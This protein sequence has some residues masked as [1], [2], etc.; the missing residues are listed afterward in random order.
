MPSEA[1]NDLL[2]EEK[3]DVDCLE[4]EVRHATALGNCH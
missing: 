1:A 3:A 2:A 4:R